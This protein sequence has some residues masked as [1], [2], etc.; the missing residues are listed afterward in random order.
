MDRVIINQLLLERNIQ[1]IDFY[2]NEEQLILNK[3]S[4]Q[5]YEISKNYKSNNNSLILEDINKFKEKITNLTKKRKQYNVVLN[6]VI[7]KYND[8]GIETIEIFEGD[9]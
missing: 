4:N 1:Q 9:L 8:L 2:T 5:L 6:K 3:I 7:Q